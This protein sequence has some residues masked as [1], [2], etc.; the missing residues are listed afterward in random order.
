MRIAFF[1]PLAPLQTASADLIE[2]LLPHLVK[3]AQIDLFIDDGYRPVN[4]LILTRSQVYNYREFPARAQDYDLFVY[5]IGN[6]PDFH[7]YM[8]EILQQYPGVVIVH[9]LILHHFIVGLTLA[10]GDVEG[11]LSEMRHAY[12][13]EGIR[14]AQ[15]VIAGQP[16]DVYAAYP[17]VERF[18]DASLGVIVTN[19]FAERE[20]LAR[21]PN[22][23]VVYIYH[24][25]FLPYGFPDRV[26]ARTLRAQLG[27]EDR[28]VLATFGIF[29]PAK[30][31]DVCLRVFSRFLE[32]HPD[33]IYLLVGTHS[34]Y[35]DVPGMIRNL[36]LEG[37]V[38]LTGWMDPIPFVKH[39]FVPEIAV[40]LRYPDIGGTPY[41]PIRLLGLGVPTI[42]SDI[43][44]VAEI[45]EGC[46]AKIPPD[47]YEEETLLATLEY[48]AAHE[49]VRRKIGENGQQFIQEHHSCDTIAR[50]YVDF[51][52][53]IIARSVHPLSAGTDV[54]AYDQQLVREVAATLVRWGVIEDDEV[55]L[56]PIAEALAG[57]G[58]FQT[59]CPEPN[60]RAS[61]RV[62]KRNC[63]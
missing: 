27:L 6:N 37:K 25:F 18:V 47:Q 26:D 38:I 24:Q 29:I 22:A 7:G 30:R 52:E 17:L 9:D 5:V 45:P 48:L 14:A 53:E 2:G 32:T 19:H 10:R 11:Y 34:P 35:Y 41:T 59:A 56:H 36:E 44:S 42:L 16:D 55:W 4:P 49:D 58:L 62:G 43:E 8:Y 46:C 3:Y 50:Q 39:M 57:L 33:A 13:E 51:F 40:H 23:R 63:D 12:G 21:R 28:F 1:T 20:I 15:R 31:L 60:R 61:R 54:G